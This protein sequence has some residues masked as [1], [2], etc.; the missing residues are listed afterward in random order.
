MV[1]KQ[2]KKFQ[3][4]TKGYVVSEVLIAIGSWFQIVGA[5]TEK[6]RLPIFSLVLGTKCC[7]EKDDLRVLEI[8]EK[9]SRLTKYDEGGCIVALYIESEKQCPQKHNHG[10]HHMRWA[11]Y[12]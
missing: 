11:I 6:A 10:E 2:F 7:L 4:L 3:F 9:C 1:E 5:A 12:L 8:S